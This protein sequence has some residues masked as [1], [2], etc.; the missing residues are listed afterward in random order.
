MRNRWLA[1]PILAGGVAI[2]AA[3]GSSGAPSS[4]NTT[5]TGPAAS[6]QGNTA[7]GSVTIKTG[8]TKDG[9][10]LTTASGQTLYWFAIDTPQASKCN[11]ACTQFWPPVIGHPVAASGTSLPMSFG[12]IKRSDG[13]TQATYDGHPLYTYSGDS[14]PGQI[15]GNAVNIEG[16]L[17]WGMTPNGAKPSKGAS[18]SSKSSSG[19]GG[20]Y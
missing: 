10:V 6:Q 19:G 1:A 14:A 12:T 9:T 20:Y 11:G 13:K 16:G 18:G 15:N 4:A 17:W 3:C 8:S 7:A 2:L 5:T